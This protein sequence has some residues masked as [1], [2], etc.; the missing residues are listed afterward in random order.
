MKNG[1]R[2]CK[3]IEWRLQ[4]SNC[5]QIVLSMQPPASAFTYCDVSCASRCT[6]LWYFVCVCV[7]V[8]VCVRERERERQRERE[9]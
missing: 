5:S 2:N 6:K 1:S 7:C 3:T 8:C 9:D 4:V